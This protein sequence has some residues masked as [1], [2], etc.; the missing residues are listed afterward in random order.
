[1]IIMLKI[2]GIY[3]LYFFLFLLLKKL[4]VKKHL[5]NYCNEFIKLS[6]LIIDQFIVDPD[7]CQST[8]EVEIS[9][10]CIQD[11]KT[12]LSEH[13]FWSTI[14]GWK[15]LAYIFFWNDVNSNLSFVLERRKFIKK[16]YKQL[17]LNN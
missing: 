7:K 4:F 3:G 12:I 10:E 2:I 17:Q 16:M 14:I 15:V 6:T 13:I 1:M 9:V 8:D 5:S 11:M